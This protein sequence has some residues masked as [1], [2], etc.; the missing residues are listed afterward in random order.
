M[1][2][3][4]ANQEKDRVELQAIRDK[5]KPPKPETLS[6]APDQRQVRNELLIG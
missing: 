6:T 5:L 3:L 1:S 2:Q 4:Q